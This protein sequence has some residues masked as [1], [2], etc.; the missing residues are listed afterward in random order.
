[1]GRLRELIEAS[2]ALDRAEQ[3]IRALTDTALAALSTVDL[4]TEAHQALADLAI[5]ATRRP[6]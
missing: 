6:A 2:G 4:D 1:M 5:A 3:R